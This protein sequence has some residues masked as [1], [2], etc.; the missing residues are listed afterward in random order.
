MEA[1]RTYDY[2]ARARQ[3]IFDWIRPLSVEEYGRTFPFAHGTLGRTLT[4][5]LGSE[6]YYV[7][8]IEGRA[9]PPYEQWRFRPESPLSFAALEVAWSEEAG[10]TRAALGAVRDWT[11][12]IEYTVDGDAGPLIVT[13]SPADIFTQ[14]AL[15]EV[16]HRAQAMAMLRQLG[17]PLED[18]D[19]NAMMDR[20]RPAGQR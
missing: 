11:A 1:L 15:H 8:R 7:Q 16:H 14:L 13:T 17:V 9:V 20:R 12:E 4:H 5:I 18:L 3:R 10:R 6:W 19:F 2:L